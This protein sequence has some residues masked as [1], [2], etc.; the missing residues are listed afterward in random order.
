MCEYTVSSLKTL[1]AEAE[2]VDSGKYAVEKVIKAHD[3]KR[4]F[5]IVILDWMMPDQ[6]GIETAKKI[7]ASIN[8]DIPILIVSAYD[9][10]EIENKAV[11]VNGFLQKPL[12]R[13]TLY[14][15]LEKY[16][17]KTNEEDYLGRKT[18]NYDFTNKNI[19]LVEDNELNRDIAA[20]LLSI[21]KANIECASNG[22]ECLDMFKS[23]EENYYDIILMDIQMPVMN[24][25]E[26]TKLI[27][28]LERK[29]SKTI[30]ILAMTADVFSEDIHA[31]ITAGM[32]GYLS[33]P[34]NSSIMLKEINKLI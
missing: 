1:G 30:P 34:L 29:D 24:G 18:N 14:R 3:E 31:A 17:L 28:N 15:A 8:D 13:S 22:K 20:E 7:R 11:G 9:W 4:D 33:K 32:N 6:D 16:V 25:Y 27:R 21:T 23:C 2:W 19:L 10:S 12:F 26:A 5:D